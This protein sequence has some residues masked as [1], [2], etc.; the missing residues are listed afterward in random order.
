MKTFDES[1]DLNQLNRLS[2]RLVFDTADYPMQAGARRRE[3]ASRHQ[4]YEVADY[5]LDL[6]LEQSPQGP[7]AVLVGQLADR[8]DPLKPQTEVPILLVSGE[9]LLTRTV[10]NRQ[11]EF[12][13]EYQP[14]ASVSL[15]LPVGDGQMIEVPLDHGAE[16]GGGEVAPP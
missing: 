2:A 15:C 9:E 3:A 6:R 10:S 14:A 5:C 4:L 8:Q 16:K 12:Q 13:L 7:G 11:G 1:T